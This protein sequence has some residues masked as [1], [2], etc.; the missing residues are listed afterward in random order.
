MEVEAR[1]PVLAHAS[2]MPATEVP[3]SLEPMQLWPL[4]PLAVSDGS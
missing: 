2:G 1:D 3:A 4:R